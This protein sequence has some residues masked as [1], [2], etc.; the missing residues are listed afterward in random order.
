MEEIDLLNSGLN[1]EIKILIEEPKEI[2]EGNNYNSQSKQ[3]IQKD[4]Y[5]NLINTHISIKSASRVTSCDSKSIR[6]CCT[7]K[8][9]TAKGFK[10]EY[11]N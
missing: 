6:E 8:R 2:N 5:D 7:G 3:I 10:W 9:Q 1:I 11:L 4:L